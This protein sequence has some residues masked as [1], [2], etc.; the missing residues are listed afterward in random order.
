M[1]D[2][3]ATRRG[4]LGRSFGYPWRLTPSL[5][6]WLLTT[7]QLTPKNAVC[8]GRERNETGPQHQGYRVSGCFDHLL[9][10]A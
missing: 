8:P 7:N 2:T 10:L 9:D 1:T 3:L 6:P 5:P 4:N